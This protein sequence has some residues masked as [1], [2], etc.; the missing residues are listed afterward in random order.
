M[1]IH[2]TKKLIKK[3]FNRLTD[4]L[5]GM[6]YA[7][8]LTFSETKSQLYGFQVH[9]KKISPKQL[10]NH[11]ERIRK[12]GWIEKKIIADKIFYSLT[13]KG[14]VKQLSFKLRIAQKQRAKQAT[15]IIFDIP[16]EK[17]T[18]RDY[19]RRLLKD[20]KFTMIQKS[21]FIAPFILP[22]EFYDLLKELDLLKCVKVIEGKLRF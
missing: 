16:E 15:I 14:R 18:F 7:S 10:Y 6:Y 9:P 12:Q 11:I 22:Q 1:I 21:V 4:E 3:S 2:K 8:P 17:R 13:A 20:M 19:L 5:L